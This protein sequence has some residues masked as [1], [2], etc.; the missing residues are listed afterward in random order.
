MVAVSIASTVE[1]VIGGEVWWVLLSS[2]REV[3]FGV[4]KEAIRSYHLTG[5]YFEWLISSITWHQTEVI[6]SSAGL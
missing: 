5:G 3:W 1:V 2:L 4:A 6:D